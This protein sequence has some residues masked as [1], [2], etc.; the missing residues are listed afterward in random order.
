MRPARPMRGFSR[1]RNYN[2]SNPESMYNLANSR[3]GREHFQ[4]AP[5]VVLPFGEFINQSV[6]YLKRQ[7]HTNILIARSLTEHDG[8]GVRIL[9]LYVSGILGPKGIR[10]LFYGP[11][12][13][14]NED[15][16]KQFDNWEWSK[17]NSAF[18][19]D[20]LQR[21]TLKALVR[22]GESFNQIVGDKDC[23]AI[24]PIDALNVPQDLGVG[25]S[26]E[27]MQ[28]G[29]DYNSD[30]SPK[31]YHIRP[32]SEASIL[33]GD[34][35]TIYGETRLV[36]AS[37]MIHTFRINIPGAGRGISWFRGAYESLRDLRI[38][39]SQWRELMDIMVALPGFFEVPEYQRIPLTDE[40]LDK[41]AEEGASDAEIKAR[42]E[43]AGAKLLSEMTRM[44]PRRR[45]LLPPEVKWQKIEYPGELRGELLRDTIKTYMRR[46]C[47]A[48][49]ISF[50][51]LSGEL[52]DNNYS[53][54]RQAAI[55]NK[56]FFEIAQQYII[57]FMRRVAK[58]W[59]YWNQLDS[60]FPQ[61]LTPEF[62]APT[63]AALDPQKEARAVQTEIAS[64]ITSRR[65]E[66]LKRGLNP[67]QIFDEIQQEIEMGLQRDFGEEEKQIG[68]VSG[69]KD[70]EVGDT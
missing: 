63:V 15:V 64:S 3:W 2:N 18:L 61:D 41:L 14:I 60:T 67:D 7:V 23:L 21:I 19:H 42:Q 4:S 20:E 31:S 57:G 30:G 12:G 36:P 1:P 37:Q 8:Y 25:L 66:I 48:V 40:E 55:E 26:A 10:V 29:I 54:L 11:D 58:E 44:N 45:M 69:E 28:N 65:R 56:E 22:D 68:D 43:A 70:T 50:A 6:F 46:I 51:S 59:L 5:A 13:S 24:Q 34:M 32:F 16:T 47:R 49:N 62:I 53:A 39:E 27:Y 35:N 17:L 33:T 52:S 38:F 9:N